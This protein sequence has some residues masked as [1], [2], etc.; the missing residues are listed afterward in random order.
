MTVAMKMRT[1]VHAVSDTAALPAVKAVAAVCLRNDVRATFVAVNTP[2]D[3]EKDAYG[4]WALG[5]AATL[6]EWPGRIEGLLPPGALTVRLQA[7]GAERR[8][9]FEGDESWKAR[10][11]AAGIA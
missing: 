8:V 4:W 6:I 1:C 10:L 9:V 7:D 2:P 3:E 11:E 5:G